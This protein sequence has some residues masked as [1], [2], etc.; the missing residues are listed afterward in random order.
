MLLGGDPVAR[1]ACTTDVLCADDCRERHCGPLDPNG[2]PG[3]FYQ[4]CV[5]DCRAD[6]SNCAGWVQCM[7]GCEEDRDALRSECQA[8][9]KSCIRN[10]CRVCTGAA[11]S[12]APATVGCVDQ[13]RA[14][15]TACTERLQGQR[16]RV[17]HCRTRCQDRCG[18]FTQFPGALAEC[19]DRC[20]SPPDLDCK[21][22]FQACRD[23]CAVQ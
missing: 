17:R 15:R 14:T 6:Q 20:G 9:R 1:A 12:A 3:E 2:Q 10:Q 11:T 7:R 5:S 16:A 22:D 19:R 18:K 4:G 13:C 8:R 21:G 23:G